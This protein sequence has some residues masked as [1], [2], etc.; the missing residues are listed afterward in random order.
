MGE[1]LDIESI[2]AAL[3]LEEKASLCLGSDFWHTAPVERLGVPAVMVADGPHGLRKQPDEADH[4]GARRQHPAT[5]FPTACALA[6]S[7]NPDLRT[8]GG[9]GPRRGGARRG[10]RGAARP[11]HQHQAVA[12]VRPQLRVLLR[13]PLPVRC[14]RQRRSCSGVQSQGVGTSLKHYAANNQETDRMRVSADVDE[15][16]LREI[17]LPAFE[18]IVKEAQPWTVMCSYNRVNGTYASRAPLAAH[19]RCCATSG[20]SR[21]SSSPTGA[22]STTGSRAVRAGLDLEM[23]PQLGGATGALRRRRCAPVSSTRRSSTSR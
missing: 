11:G 22:R 9:G 15:R 14:A 3:T 10:G 12:A 16:T 6:S 1:H 23:P 5:C 13:G 21:A 4:V 7:W 2:V 20:A 19:R 17:Y 8:A 18:R